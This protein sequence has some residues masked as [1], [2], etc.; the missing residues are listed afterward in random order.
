M[1]LSKRWAVPLT[2]AAMLAALPGLTQTTDATA[3]PQPVQ[4]VLDAA[5]KTA[6]ASNKSILV[7]FGASW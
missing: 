4:T 3:K 1:I 6:K 5:V 2:L 7:H